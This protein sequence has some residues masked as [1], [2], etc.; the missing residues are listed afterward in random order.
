MIRHARRSAL[1]ALVGALGPRT[2][3][4]HHQQVVPEDFTLHDIEN[5]PLDYFWCKCEE[6]LPDDWA[7]ALYAF[8][9]VDDPRKLRYMARAWL[10]NKEIDDDDLPVRDSFVAW[11]PERAM[12]D[13]F[14]KLRDML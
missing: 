3:P 5:I 9:D 14:Y 6:F 8:R 12:E 1:E 2:R 4:N 7:M 13:L 10:N 11:W